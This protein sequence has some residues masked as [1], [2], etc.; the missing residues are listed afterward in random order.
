MVVGAAVVV[1]EEIKEVVVIAEREDHCPYLLVIRRRRMEEEMVG[2]VEQ[3]AIKAM[4]LTLLLMVPTPLHPVIVTL[5]L[6]L[7]MELLL[8][9][10]VHLLMGANNG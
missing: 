7:A 9:H 2:M 1:K 10:M 8:L 4:V 3:E 6:P 5:L